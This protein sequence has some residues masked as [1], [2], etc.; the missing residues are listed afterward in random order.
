MNA[1]MDTAAH[2]ILPNPWDAGRDLIKTCGD[3]RSA[4]CAKKENIAKDLQTN[5]QLT[6][7]QGFNVQQNHLVLVQNIL[8]GSVHGQKGFKYHTSRYYI[9]KL[10]SRCRQKTN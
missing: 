2:I 3:N 6:A 7:N 1:Q 9:K 5:I 10:L 4:N 8:L